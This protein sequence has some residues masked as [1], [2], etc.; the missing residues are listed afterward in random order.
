MKFLS[1]FFLLHTTFFCFG[2]QKKMDF[3]LRFGNDFEHEIV[4]IF[5]NGK[6][7]AQN[8]KLEATLISPQSLIS[9][10]FGRILVTTRGELQ[11]KKA[12]REEQYFSKIQLNKSRLNVRILIN[13]TEKRFSFNLKKGKYLYANYYC[14]Q[15]KDC[16]TKVL[17]VIQQKRMQP[18]F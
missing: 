7:V 12:F 17:T 10:Q 2:Q 11:Q 15:K 5:L 8:M 16:K 13:N 1:I 6:L 14:T 4:T 18:M 3:D 9:S